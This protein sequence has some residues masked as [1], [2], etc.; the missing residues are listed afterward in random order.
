MAEAEYW[1]DAYI[2]KKRDAASAI[3]LIRSGQRVFIGSALFLCVDAISIKF[4]AY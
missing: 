2:E 4:W 3:R 1:V